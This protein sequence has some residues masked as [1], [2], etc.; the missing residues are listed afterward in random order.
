MDTVASPLGKISG[1]SPSSMILLFYPWTEFQVA[2]EGMTQYPYATLSKL[3]LLEILTADV[4][5]RATRFVTSYRQKFPGSVPV[6]VIMGQLLTLAGQPEMAMGE[7]KEALKIL[8]DNPLIWLCLG[9][10]TNAPLD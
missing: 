9:R 2:A 5:S 1:A 3:L 7:F 10:P 6:I 4:D 8:P